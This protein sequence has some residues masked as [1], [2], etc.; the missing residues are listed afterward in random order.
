MPSN[1]MFYLDKDGVKQDAALHK[2][3]ENPEAD[4]RMC[5]ESVE[6]WIGRGKTREEAIKFVFGNSLQ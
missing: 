2:E 4:L 6:N 1:E 3:M 5:W